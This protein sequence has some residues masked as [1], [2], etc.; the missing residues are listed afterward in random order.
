VPTGPPTE[1]DG[2][3]PTR[4]A[5]PRERRHRQ[6]AAISFSDFVVHGGGIPL[7]FTHTYNSLR[8]AQDG[9]LGFGWPD[10]YNRF[11]QGRGNEPDARAN[12]QQRACPATRC[13]QPGGHAPRGPRAAGE[14]RAAPEGTAQRKG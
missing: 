1:Y 14:H 12:T 5:S 3:I 13:M 8:A 4:R 11:L 2:R 6:Y 7:Q 9:R 10:S